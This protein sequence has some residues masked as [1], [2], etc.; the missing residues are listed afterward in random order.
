V[1]DEEQLGEL[2]LASTW[3]EDREGGGTGME[4]G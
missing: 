1:V 2:F 3:R 4:S